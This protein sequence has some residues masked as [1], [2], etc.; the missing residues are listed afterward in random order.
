MSQANDLLAAALMDSNEKNVAE[1]HIVVGGDRYITVPEGVKKIGVQYDHNVSTVTFDCPR[2]WDGHDMSKMKVYINYMRPD[3]EMGSHLCENVTVDSANNDIMHFDWLISGHVTELEGNI[4]FLVCVKNVNLD[5][6]EQNH[7]NSEVSADLIVSQGLRTHETVLRFYPDIITQILTRLESGETAY[8]EWKNATEEDL[9]KWKD[10][11]SEVLDKV[12]S[13]EFAYTHPDSGVTAGTY[14]SVT[15]DEQGHVTEGSNPTLPIN[16]GG[17]GATNAK[18]AQYNMLNDIPE[19]TAALTDN[20]HSAITL[21]T[22]SAANGVLAKTKITLLWDYIKGKISSVLGLTDTNYSGTAAKATAD[23]SGNNIVDT[24]LK[25]SGG[26]ISSANTRALTIERSA[27]GAAN[28]QFKNSDGA[29]GAVGM[30]AVNGSLIRY[31]SDPSATD[32]YTVLDTGNYKDTVTPANIG[33]L[34]NMVDLSMVELGFTANSTV[35]VEDFLL[36][37]R[38]KTGVN[39]A[40]VNFRWNAANSAIVSDGTTTVTINGGVIYTSGHNNILSNTWSNYHALYFHQTSGTF[41]KFSIT[42]SGTAKV[43]V[44]N[45]EVYAFDESLMSVNKGSKSISIY[46]SIDVLTTDDLPVVSVDKG[47]TGATTAKGAQYNILNDMSHATDAVGDDFNIVYRLRTGSSETKGV[48]YSRSVSLLW[49]Y[50]KGKISSVLGLTASNYNGTAA[51]ATADANGNNITDT[52]ATK[53]EIVNGGGDG[54]VLSDIIRTTDRTLPSSTAGPISV[55]SIEADSQQDGTPTPTNPQEFAHS[56]IKEIKSVGKNLQY[57]SMTFDGWTKYKDG[58]TA[59]LTTSKRAGGTVAKYTSTMDFLI[60]PDRYFRAGTYTISFEARVEVVDTICICSSAG[61][62]HTMTADLTTGYKRYSYTFELAEDTIG[63]FSVG[64]PEGSTIKNLRVANI[65]LESGSVVT[66]YKSYRESTIK[67]SKPIK[68]YGTGTAR[69]AICKQDGV[70]CIL[71]KTGIHT[72][73][74]SESWVKNDSDTNNYLYYVMKD[75]IG[76]TITKNTNC[77]SSRFPV[78]STI[79]DDVITPYSSSFTNTFYLGARNIGLSTNTAEALKTWLASNNVTLMYELSSYIAEP[80]PTGDQEALRQL[81]SFD[82]MTYIY[83]D[84]ELEPIV[85]MDYP[86]SLAG[87]HILKNQLDLEMVNRSIVTDIKPGSIEHIPV[88]SAKGKIRVKRILGNI[89]A[90]RDYYEGNTVSPSNPQKL[91]IPGIDGGLTIISHG[92]ELLDSSVATSATDNGVTFTVNTDGSIEANGTASTTSAATITIMGGKR[93][94]AIPLPEWLKTGESYM[95]SDGTHA[96][97]TDSCVRIVFYQPN[98]KQ[99]IYANRVFTVPTDALYYRIATFIPKGTAV[100][101]LIF[102]PTLKRA[103]SATIAVPGG[104]CAIKPYT[105]VEENLSRANY[106]DSNGTKWITDEI[107]LYADGSGQLIKRTAKVVLDGSET[108]IAY[109]VNQEFGP[110]KSFYTVTDTLCPGLS[111]VYCDSYLMSSKNFANLQDKTIVQSYFNNDS[112]KTAHVAIYDS[113]YANVTDF[114]TALAAKNVTFYG[115]LKEPI[116]TDLSVDEVRSLYS[117]EAYDYITHVIVDSTTNPM[118]LDFDYP[119]CL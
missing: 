27:K 28:I 77:Y 113:S 12:T 70:Y 115:V 104:L 16:Q 24:Y 81:E 45:A 6:E 58:G 10:D 29:L 9:D 105:N 18:G 85:I 62:L 89:D 60:P 103:T 15:V 57:N 69:D 44:N 73:N 66:E 84:S 14:R 61:I 13:G 3:G 72:F 52:Y 64:I 71:R 74:G 8:T 82:V 110:A 23:V 49:D 35:S 5:G 20:D 94:E 118:V 63:W 68:L 21:A 32:S 55:V 25:K 39:A 17:T 37:L 48:I 30:N 11:I 22:P 43:Y 2:Y 34:K 76:L 56:E 51:R 90:I 53:Q 93:D 97:H 117:L 116:V 33:A 91:K 83:T 42:A 99:V 111:P 96:T 50:I 75:T 87:A 92:E 78:S 108:W 67:L 4:T 86:T 114:K 65:Q 54:N 112:E 109:N 47:G 119:V 59:A 26:I 88:N 107:A 101:N 95:I 36:A 7:W 1:G 38:T 41:Y 102:K 100:T 98:N 46:K 79:A 40:Q 31:K 80:L 19:R 106:T